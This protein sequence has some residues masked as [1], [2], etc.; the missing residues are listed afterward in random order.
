M[1]RPRRY[2]DALR[3]RLLETAADA[4]A[5]HGPGGLS[6]RDVARGAETST[7]AVYGLFGSRDA[8]VAAV[9][10]EAFARFAAHLAAVPH[11]DHPD[12]DLFELGLAYRAFALAEPHFYRVMFDVAPSTGRGVEEPTFAVLR[13]A[14]ERTAPAHPAPGEAAFALWS[15]VHG[16]V[17]L[18]L[19]GLAPGSD[20]ERTARFAKTLREVGPALVGS[21]A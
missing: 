21:R 9:G 6:L 16:L 1:A 2:D 4:I 13:D 10:H 15:L 20:D 14:V 17:S 11:T 19:A 8:L 3:T 5:A 12:R 18:E 7:S